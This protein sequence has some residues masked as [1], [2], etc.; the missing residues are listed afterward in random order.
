M[1]RRKKNEDDDRIDPFESGSNDA[2]EFLEDAISQIEE[3]MM[4]IE[5]IQGDIREIYKELGGRGYDTP[6]VRRVISTKK[7]KKQNLM[8]FEAQEAFFETYMRALGLIDY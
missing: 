1:A 8:K 4:E 6:T 3:K 7:K 5:S 2:A